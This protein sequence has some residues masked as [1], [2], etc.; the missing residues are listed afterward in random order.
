MAN[1][2]VVTMALGKQTVV[3]EAEPKTFKSKTDGF[4]FRNRVKIGADEYY[5]QLIV[6]K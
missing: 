5:V 1:N 6:S 2:L 4:Y 3:I